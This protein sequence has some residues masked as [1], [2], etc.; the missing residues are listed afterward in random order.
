[1][2]NKVIKFFRN[3]PDAP[4][5]QFN[6]AFELYRQSEGKNAGTERSIN[7]QGYSPSA[8]QNLLY[9][10]QKLHS[11]SD[12]E[13]EPVLEVVKKEE[14]QAPDERIA[15]L[16]KV[17]G[18][19]PEEYS[20]WLESTTESNQTVDNLLQFAVSV[21]NEKAVEVLNSVILYLTESEGQ[22]DGV[23]KLDPNSYIEGKN[24]ETTTGDLDELKKDNENL[25]SENEELQDE[26]FDLQEQ[27]EELTNEI[28]Q[29]K[30]APKIT[31]QSIRV[32]F[33]F[34]NNPDCPDELKILTADKITAWNGYLKIQEQLA[35]IEAGEITASDS[36]KAVLAKNAID[37]FAE[38]QKI[39]DELN[40][41][42]TTGKVLGSHPVF[43]RLQLSREVETMTTDELIKYKNASSKYFSDNKKQLVTAE[44]SKDEEQILKINSRVDDR[45]LKLDLVNKKLGVPAK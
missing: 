7:A 5:E 14:N 12:V 38:N 2:K 4:H 36:E 40:A 10:L 44:K 15:I 11:I 20:G 19:L 32:E 41:Y 13:K 43:K 30:S 8:L 24:E 34:L 45:K 1:M 27:N 16:E 25:Q 28:D 37:Y 23:L 17:V 22:K 21:G 6:Q 3:L 39:Y 29:L 31:Q 18:L 26:N 33:P 35:K 42:Q 9:D